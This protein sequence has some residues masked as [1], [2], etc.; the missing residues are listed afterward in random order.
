MISM[1]HD[2]DEVSIDDY[3]YDSVCLNCRSWIIDGI[4]GGMI[5]ARGKGFSNPDDTCCQFTAINSMDDDY[6]IYLNKSKKME[7]WRSSF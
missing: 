4:G 6:D 1:Y 5:C 7:I 2:F 3:S